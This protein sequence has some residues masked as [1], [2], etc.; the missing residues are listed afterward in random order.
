[1][2]LLVLY[3]YVCSVVGFPFG[4]AG[5]E[6]T[7]NMGD[8]SLIPGLGRSPGEGKGYPLQ[9]S[10]LE[11]S[12]DCII[13]G[14]AKSWTQLSG[15]HYAQLCLTVR[16]TTHCGSPVS[17]VHGI[18]QARILEWVAISSSRGSFQLRDRTC[19]SCGSNIG[20]QILCH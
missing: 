20:R 12:M 3:V 13:H 1:M 18:L 7:C 8:L 15:F 11:K 5:K 6:S 10:G 9:Y 19:V 14:V 2:Q 16:D 17:S 4:S